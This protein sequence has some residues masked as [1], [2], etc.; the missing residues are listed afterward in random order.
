MRIFG[1]TGPT[2]AGK[3]AVTA[4]L[5]KRGIPSI[6]ADSVYHTLL[7]QGGPMTA[8][9]ATTFGTNILAEDG[10]VD[11]KC[12]GQAVFGKANTPDLLQ[13]LNA[14]THKYVIAAIQAQLKD[15]QANGIHAAVID[16]PQLFEAGLE[17]SCEAVIGVLASHDIRLARIMK[18]D[19]LTEEAAL[20]RINAQHTDDFFRLHCHHI[21]ENNN[22][23]A[24]LEAQID[25]LL[26]TLQL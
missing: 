18:R 20:H 5:A 23:L 10:K 16:A 8:E 22:D 4:I 2:G 15:W 25:T 12:L 9:L 7:A 26:H 3:G 17:S 24:A 13:A 19:E 14:I 21:L 1:L 11:R 6:D